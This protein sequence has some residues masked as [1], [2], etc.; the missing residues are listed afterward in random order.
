[1]KTF[2][3]PALVVPLASSSFVRRSQSAACVLKFP[4]A[5]T[6]CSGLTR[7]DSQQAKQSG[8]SVLSFALCCE[9]SGSRR[10][11]APSLLFAQFIPHAT[12][13]A[14]GVVML[15]TLAAIAPLPSLI[16]CCALPLRGATLKSPIRS[17]SQILPSN[18]PSRATDNFLLSHLHTSGCSRVAERSPFSSTVEEPAA[19]N[20][21]RVLLGL[22]KAAMKRFESFGYRI[23]RPIVKPETNNAVLLAR[24]TATMKII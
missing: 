14:S 11:P 23:A 10:N 1:M 13:D 19:L 15:V 6:R 17:L 4:S 20:K 12:H 16:V 18:S 8:N 5:Q 24:T 3:E 22:L 2:L 9:M 7:H 21:T